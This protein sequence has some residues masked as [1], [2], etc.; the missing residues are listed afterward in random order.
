MAESSD[1]LA[2][3]IVEAIKD[4]RALWWALVS[5]GALVLALYLA[6]LAISLFFAGVFLTLLFISIFVYLD[7]RSSSSIDSLNLSADR[8]GIDNV[9]RNSNGETVGIVSTDTKQLPAI[10]P[11]TKRR[12]NL[13]FVRAHPQHVNIRNNK[14]IHK[15]NI[16]EPGW[17]AVVAVFGNEPDTDHVG[18]LT[19]LAATIVYD[20]DHNTHVDRACWINEDSHIVKLSKGQRKELVLGIL[21]KDGRFFATENDNGLGE[22][23]K[24]RL[25]GG[26]KFKPGETFKARVQ[27][28]S[29]SMYEEVAQ[30]HE[31]TVNPKP[32]LTIIKN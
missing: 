31:F 28:H 3:K 4:I 9:T 6:P 24:L 11:K 30:Q 8:P 19:S 27:L 18:H 10:D 23:I 16:E 15:A 32:E 1:S 13:K 20:D 12:P 7:V 14:Q 5:F 17:Y 26:H 29:S 25:L 21:A 22:G 2:R